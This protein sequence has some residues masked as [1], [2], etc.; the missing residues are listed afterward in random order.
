MSDAV[1]PSWEGVRE[2][3]VAR[4]QR[5]DQKLVIAVLIGLVSVTGAF[6]TWRSSQLGE[7]ATDKD[8]QAVAES[9]LQEQSRANV[10]TRLKDE[11]EAFAQYKEDLTNADLLDREADDLTAAGFADQ[12]VLARDQASE[13]R[14]I[15]SNLASLT[16][17]T[18]YVVFDETTGLPTDFL[19]DDRR[20]DLERSD[21]ETAKLNPNRTVE[22]AVELRQR[23]QRL[24][25]WT[26]ALVLSVVLLTFATITLNARARPVIASVAVV[27]YLV[28]ASVALLGD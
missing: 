15:A 23:S 8:R 10:V 21:R 27:I 28:S 2:R 9:V 13:L 1:V 5:I 7:Q 6:I 11:Q 12:A 26:I 14:E 18:D 17:S 3:R 24:E 16:F 19:V 20:A 22:Q 25:G 4:L